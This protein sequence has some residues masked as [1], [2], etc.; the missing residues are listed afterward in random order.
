MTKVVLGSSG[1]S[2]IDDRLAI[3]AALDAVEARG[4]GVVH[5]TSGMY[6]IGPSNGAAPPVAGDYSLKM[7]DNVHL[8]LDVDA[9]IVRRFSGGHYVNATIRNRDQVNG[10]ENLRVTGGTITT[11]NSANNGKHLGF[12]KTQF[13]S[14]SDMRF[15]GV[16]D[17][18]N[19]IFYDCSDVTISDLVMDSGNSLTE[20][21]LH[22][23][24]GQRIAVDNCIIRCGDDCI[25]I[26]FD[27]N[28]VATD[29][30]DVVI[31]NCYLFSRAANAFKLWVAPNVNSTI[32]RVSVSNIVAKCGDGESTS[33][34]GIA[35]VDQNRDLR[36]SDVDVQG[37]YLDASENDGEGVI[38]DGAQRVRFENLVVKEPWQRVRIDGSVDVELRDCT[39]DGPRY[40][41]Q[42]CVLT[43]ENAG[44]AN[45]R[46]AG[47]RYKDA[48]HHGIQIGANHAVDGFEVSKALVDGSALVGVLIY[49]GTSGVVSDNRITGSGTYGIQEISPSNQ[50]LLM[51]NRV[52]GNTLDGLLF[53]GASTEAIRNMGPLVQDSGGFRQT[54]DSWVQAPTNAGQ[55]SVE[56][57]RNSMTAPS[58]RFRAA[59]AGSL[60][61][62]VVTST[63]NRMAGTL[64]VTVFKNTGLA[65]AA[66]TTTGLSATLDGTRP[67]R[68][69]VT[70]DKDLD[71]FAAGDELYVVVTTDATWAPTA[72]A[73]RCA[74]EIED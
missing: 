31:S 42:P 54:I 61:G 13:L 30:S 12:A 34:A 22:F 3:Q 32:S 36:I 59:R 63:A 58:V 27:P 43:A 38:V 64:T 10:N 18:W 55:T 68:H 53:T 29:V 67:N 44:C 37:F 8:S 57:N 20:D 28:E 15:R 2:A 17:E 11:L 35:I 14:V 52:A 66:G 23:T 50:N 56:L 65:G 9:T 39:V 72:A 69:A 60:T 46:I 48:T 16:F 45:I 40:A 19:T 4:G 5:L 73:I 24:G 62:I 33:S 51:G 25:A 47:G 26:V 7:G 41:T 74:I 49:N 71:T 70:Q 21:G 6:Y 1:N